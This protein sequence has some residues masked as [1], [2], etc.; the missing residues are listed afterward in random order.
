MICGAA[1]YLFLTSKAMS[2]GNVHEEKG[3][4]QFLFRRMVFI[5]GKAAR[6]L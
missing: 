3:L 1:L 6:G 5:V 4:G 2:G